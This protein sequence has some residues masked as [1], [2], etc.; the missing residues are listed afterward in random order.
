MVRDFEKG[1]AN[2][3][4]L[5]YATI[6]L[7]PKEDDARTLKKFGPINLIKCSFKIL[8]NALN[9]RL[10]TIYDRLLTHNQPDFVKGK[11]ILESVLAA[12]EFIHGAVKGVERD[13]IKTRL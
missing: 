13:C 8:S 5:N 9:N 3:A 4:R 1:E 12:H 10:E 7:I 6:I 11:Y 2:V